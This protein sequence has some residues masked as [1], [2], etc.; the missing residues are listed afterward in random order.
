MGEKGR[1]AV[2]AAGFLGM[3]VFCIGAAL[4]A[5]FKKKRWL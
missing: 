1:L 5:S 2:W 4:L 3:A